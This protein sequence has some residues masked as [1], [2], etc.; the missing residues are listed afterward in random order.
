MCAAVK[1]WITELTLIHKNIRS[2]RNSHTQV[3]RSIW[4]KTHYDVT[5]K[6][7]NVS[8]EDLDRHYHK[9]PS[10]SYRTR[11]DIIDN[12]CLDI[13]NCL[14]S[15]YTLTCLKSLKIPKGKSK[16]DNTMAEFK[17]TIKDVQNTAQ[18]ARLS[19]TNPTKS[20][21]LTLLFWKGKQFL[22]H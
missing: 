4:C 2:V 17:R 9:Y 21:E 5:D 8:S 12:V 18:K 1:V 10:W 22:L 7:N 16:T 19:N 14:Y 3:Y 15:I 13:Q 11:W 20:Q 6:N